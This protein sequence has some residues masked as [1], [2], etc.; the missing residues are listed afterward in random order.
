MGV[1]YDAFCN[2]GLFC[3]SGG[4]I[5][6]CKERESW[7][8]MWAFERRGVIERDPESPTRGPGTC[9]STIMVGAVFKYYWA[10]KLQVGLACLRA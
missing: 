1:C 2:S 8:A 7:S 9:Q 6:V 4:N 10:F 3:N 5:V